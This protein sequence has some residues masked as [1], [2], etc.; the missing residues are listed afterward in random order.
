MKDVKF[1]GRQYG[2]SVWKPGNGRVADVISYDTETTMAQGGAEIPSY[3]LGTVCDGRSVYMI[4]RS[5][6]LSFWQAHS[7]CVVFMHSAAFDTSVTTQ[8]TGFDFHPMVEA[9]LV[10]D[11][12][13]YYRLLGS[14]R[15]GTLPKQYSL[16]LM[17]GEILDTKLE[18]DDEIRTDFGK[19]Y[20]DGTVAYRE[21]PEDYLAYACLDAIATFR[22][23]EIMES[24]CGEAG[25]IDAVY[26]TEGG[27][28][29]EGEPVSSWGLLGHD[30]QLRGD[31]AL[32]RIER[33]GLGVDQER[34]EDI[35]VSLRKEI[36]GCRSVMGGYGFTR[37][38][39]GN[40][41][42]YE[43][44]IEGIEEERGIR[45]PRTEKAGK[46][47]QV[48]EDLLP[49]AD[50]PF[51]GAF[52]KES[53]LSKI[54]KT[55]IT[56]FK[57]GGGRVYPWYNLMV[58]TGRTSCSEPNIQNL[59]RQGGVRE[60]IVAAPGHV[61]IACDYAMLEL[62]TLA[63]ILYDR[64]GNSVMRDLINQGVDLHYRVAAEVLGVDESE[65]TKDQRQKAKAVNFGL[66]GGMGAG[67]LQAY[68]RSSYQVELTVEEACTWKDTWLELFPEMGSYLEDHD[69]LTRFGSTLDLASYPGNGGSIPPQAAA[70]IVIRV[71]GGRTETTMGRAFSDEETHWAWEQIARSRA[72]RIGRLK[73]DI[74]ARR[75]SPE[76]Q[77]EVTPGE[78]V[79]IS[80]G[81]I[82]ADRTYTK[83]RNWPFQALAADG[84]KLAL[85]DLMQ[86][87]YK[88]V[89]FIHDEV[90]VEVPE[91][92]DYKTAAEGISTCMIHAMRRVCPDVEIRTE[93]AVMRRWRKGASAVYDEEGRLIAVCTTR[94][95]ASSP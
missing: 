21:I 32:H 50:H 60:C 36:E 17:C 22:L 28:D 91:S 29:E 71:A 69:S 80:T 90:I 52:L 75:G 4:R 74:E 68:A 64:Y 14:A 20:R 38:K 77:R 87:G 94:K 23:G 9:G 27:M 45:V 11:I 26:D 89:A 88:V 78:V 37:G 31:I 5:D 66:P 81:R 6:L 65:V 51:V 10:R 24:E 57:T 70:G 33:H 35:E 67:G 30:I 47:S 18:K 42:V 12:S 41:K 95:V 62:C 3:V 16:R 58:Q 85:Y 19:F 49:F 72:G 53:E 25:W 86:A 63:Q 84:A 55:Y 46:V 83:A 56:P 15:E 54:L 7:D 48:A 13:I 82:C 73:T 34:V 76:L 43:H 93:Y 2:V 92:A 59:P 39:Q 8:A 61:L 40:Q 79:A 1:D 44:I